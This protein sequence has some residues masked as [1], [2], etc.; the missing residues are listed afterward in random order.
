M[1]DLVGPFFV[2]DRPEVFFEFVLLTFVSRSLTHPNSFRPRHAVLDIC[3]IFNFVH[4]LYR[5]VFD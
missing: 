3:S 5:F 2:M 1:S 4:H